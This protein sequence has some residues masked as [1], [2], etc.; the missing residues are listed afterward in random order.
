M[1]IKHLRRSAQACEKGLACGL[2]DAMWQPNRSCMP[3]RTSWIKDVFVIQ[4]S[5]QRSCNT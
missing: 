1:G 4:K 3:S 5:S 2:I